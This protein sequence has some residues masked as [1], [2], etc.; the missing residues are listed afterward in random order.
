MNIW[1]ED[2]DDH[3]LEIDGSED[4]EFLK[5]SE[6]LEKS[7]KKENYEKGVK[8]PLKKLEKALI[9]SYF[10][11]PSDNQ[12]SSDP[13][14]ILS[15]E[16]S[17][18][19]FQIYGKILLLFNKIDKDKDGLM[20]REELSLNL[21]SDSENKKD[22]EALKEYFGSSE[23]SISILDFGQLLT[24]LPGNFPKAMKPLDGLSTLKTITMAQIIKEIKKGVK[25]F[26]KMDG[27][28]DLRI[29]FVRFLFFKLSYD[30][31]IMH[32]YFLQ[33]LKSCL[34]IKSNLECKKIKIAKL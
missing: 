1:T 17:L 9:L 19:P 31:A 30:N 12:L 33:L 21:N 15:K 16:A 23:G 22:S 27:D 11:S 28:G 2:E 29:Q 25:E 10:S 7:F 13:L 24:R 5:N 26:K 3:E 4:S 8:D 6:N 18:D 34:L 14:D 20:S 32:P